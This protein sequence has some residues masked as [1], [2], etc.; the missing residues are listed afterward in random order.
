MTRSVGD[1]ADMLN[2]VT[3]TEPAVRIR[4]RGADAERPRSWRSTLSYVDALKGKRIGYIPSV[5]DDPFGTTGTADASKAAGWKYLTDTG[6]DDRSRWA[7]DR[8]RGGRA[9]RRQQ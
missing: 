6:R 1:L 2:V 5:W 8:G 3:G 4:P 9:S 7:H